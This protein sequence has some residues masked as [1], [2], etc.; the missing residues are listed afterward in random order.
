MF[1]ILIAQLS[2]CCTVR[3]KNTK[4]FNKNFNSSL[5]VDNGNS[6]KYDF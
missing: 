2:I 1:L 6:Q 4:Y 3:E 5:V